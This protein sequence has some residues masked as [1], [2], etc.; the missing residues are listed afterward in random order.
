[1]TKKKKN[2]DRSGAACC[3]LYSMYFPR[4]TSPLLFRAAG[5]TGKHRVGDEMWT[6]ESRR[7]GDGSWNAVDAKSHIG[8]QETMLDF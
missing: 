3:G 7:G 1:M 8:S 5:A 6:S 4:V 2:E